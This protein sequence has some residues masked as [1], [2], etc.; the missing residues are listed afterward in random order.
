MSEVP[1]P[2]IV[3]VIGD[4]RSA[5]L[6]VAKEKAAAWYETDPGCI[7]AEITDSDSV[8]DRTITGTGGTYV[9]TVETRV[10]HRWERPAYGF[11]RCVTCKMEDH[12]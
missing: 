1:E 10:A 12:S 3:T 2:F 7:R 11:T 4:T 5:V 6:R 8:G 9:V